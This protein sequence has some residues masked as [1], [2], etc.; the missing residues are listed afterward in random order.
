MSD[1]QKNETASNFREAYWQ[2]FCAMP[3]DKIT[4]S[5]LCKRAGYN[6]GTFYLH[7]TDIDS[8]RRSIEADVMA[9]MLDCVEMCLKN[10]MRGKLFLPRAMNGVL[11]LLKKDERYIVPLLGEERDPEFLEDLTQNLKP[12]WRKYVIGQECS[13][14]EAEIDLI[15]D[16]AISGGLKMIGGWLIDPRGVSPVKLSKL[17]YDLLIR[18]VSAR[19]NC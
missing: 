16:Q 1:K 3:L 6:R 14:S 5:S 19:A 9:R 15:L 11:A 17:V 12:L 2:L 18:D 13:R 4:V 8:V 10:V 7:F